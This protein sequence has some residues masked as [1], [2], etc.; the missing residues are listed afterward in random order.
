MISL[1]SITILSFS[2]YLLIQFYYNYF[3]KKLSE[4]NIIKKDEMQARKV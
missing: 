2:I 3:K 1:S 4:K